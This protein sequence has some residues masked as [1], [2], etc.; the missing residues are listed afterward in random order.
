MNRME[1]F[2][3]YQATV[4]WSIKE[5]AWYLGVTPAHVSHMRIGTT[6]VH[7]GSLILMRIWAQQFTKQQFLGRR[8]RKLMNPIGVLKD[9]RPD[10]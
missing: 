10:R 1:E 6:P 5:T 2:K 4:G 8:D 3:T 7:H 9:V